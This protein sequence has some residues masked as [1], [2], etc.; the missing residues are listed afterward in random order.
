MQSTSIVDIYIHTI[1][2]TTPNL[3]LGQPRRK[4]RPLALSNSL[5]N[6]IDAIEHPD[7]ALVAR[8]PI[9][10]LG[11]LGDLALGL[12]AAVLEGLAE[13]KDMARDL[14][15]NAGLSAQAGDGDDGHEHAADLGA[16]AVAARGR[17]GE[18][19]AV[20]RG[21]DEDGQVGVGFG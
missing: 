6:A 9:S 16:G 14:R 5:D 10:A 18:E 17:V 19:R 20:F 12:V 15:A 8:Q 13:A 2:S 7:I 21:D 4:R 11:M 1:Y 3:Q